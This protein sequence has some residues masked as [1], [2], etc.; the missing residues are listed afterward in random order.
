MATLVTKTKTCS[1]NKQSIIAITTRQA[2]YFSLWLNQAA[3]QAS[4]LDAEAKKWMQKAFSLRLL[5]V[6]VTFLKKPQMLKMQKE[7]IRGGRG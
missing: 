3:S 5:I 7:G 1:Q 6:V 4:L 2:L